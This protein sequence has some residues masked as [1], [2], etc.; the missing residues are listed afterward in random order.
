ML[1]SLESLDDL[2]LVHITR[3][4]EPEDIV[5]LG[6]TSRRMHSLM[7]RV[8]PTTQKW[9]GENFH[10]NAPVVCPHELY[11][12]GPVLSSSIK[13]LTISLL[14][15]DQGWG[16]KKGEIYVKL[17]RPG[18]RRLASPNATS[19]S[20]EGEETEIAKRRQLFGIAEHYWKH[21]RTVICDHPVV[22]KA[23]PGDFYTFM[24][25]VGN[26]GGH[27]LTVKDFRVVAT[28]FRLIYN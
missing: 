8:I 23:R 12:D 25:F 28:G 13:K 2:A 20:S 17:M 27:E 5:R 16:N 15:R 3:F 10:V 19:G 4:L 7:P 21:D 1:F 24:R 11:F 22:T 6:R 9:K 18:A 14:W 26:G